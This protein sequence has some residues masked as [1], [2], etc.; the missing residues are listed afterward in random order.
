MEDQILSKDELGDEVLVKSDLVK[1]AVAIAIYAVILTVGTT[2]CIWLVDFF[3]DKGTF[4]TI[5]GENISQQ[6][7]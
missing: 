1:L 2:V 6:N 4:S 3:R 5:R 7:S